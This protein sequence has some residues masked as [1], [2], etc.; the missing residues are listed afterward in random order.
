MD[1]ARGEKGTDVIDEGVRG[2]GGGRSA[3]GGDD[4]STTLAHGFKEGT[5]EPCL[6]IDDFGCGLTTDGGMGEGREHRRAV[7]AVDEDVL[8]FSEVHASLLG[9][10]GLGAVLVQAHHGGETV[11]REALG[12]G[13]GDHA[14]RVRRIANDGHAGVICRDGVDDFT[15]F[16]ENLAVV[17]EQVCTLHA[18]ATWLGTHEQAPVGVFKA[19][20]R[21]GGLHNALEQREGAVIELHRHTGEG[22][23]GLFKRSF[24]ELK[25]HRLIRAKHGTGSDAEKESVTDLTGGAGDCD[26]DGCFGHR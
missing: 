3:T 23:H 13:G 19:H 15:L 24:D 8:H 4:R 11:R 14:V 7:I 21:V 20:S 22:C 17:L 12:L 10:L 26:F 9:E 6:V 18:W 5:F 1:R 16:D 2:G 25:D